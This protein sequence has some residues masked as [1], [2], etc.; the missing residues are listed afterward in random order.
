MASLSSR[1]AASGDGESSGS[2]IAPSRK[3]LSKMGNPLWSV[4]KMGQQNYFVGFA[5]GSKIL[6][7]QSTSHTQA[8]EEVNQ[9]SLRT[10]VVHFCRLN[11][12]LEVQ[13]RSLNLCTTSPYDR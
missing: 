5:M 11:T 7:A 3:S 9:T 4:Q 2:L 1:A 6:V 12:C 8:T 10:F 13:Q